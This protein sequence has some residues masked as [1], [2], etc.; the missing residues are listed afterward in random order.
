MKK[1]SYIFIA[2]A[3]LS[4]A[5]CTE[6]KVIRPRTSMLGSLKIGDL[7]PK[8]IDTPAMEVLFE[9]VIFE[10]PMENIEQMKDM[11][12]ILREKPLAFTNR[13]AFKDNGFDVGFANSQAWP[14]ISAVLQTAHARKIKTSTLAVF[15]DKGDDILANILYRPIKFFYTRPDG[16]I[17]PQDI[18]PG[19]VLLRITSSPVVASRGV[20][21]VS[22]L[23]V[24]SRGRENSIARLAGMKEIGETPFGAAQFQVDMAA[25]DLIFL[26]SDEPDQGMIMLSELFFRTERNIKVRNPEFTGDPKKNVGQSAMISKDMPLARIYVILCT[27]VKG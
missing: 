23:P 12:A 13:Q 5:G 19:R 17:A 15:D 24:F 25:G 21:S 10:I 16:S 4:L 6:Q 8:R 22:V 11:F 3:Y 26:T 9:V 7:A 2:L 18:G 1:L 20:V 14:S 27:G